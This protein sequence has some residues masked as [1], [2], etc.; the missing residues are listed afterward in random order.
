MGSDTMHKVCFP[1]NG[2]PAIQRALSCYEASGIKQHLVVVGTLAGQ[3]ID[4]VTEKFPNTLFAYQRQANGTANAIRAALNAFPEMDPDANL[5]IAAG[6]RLIDPAVLE[7]FYELYFE[8]NCD[9]ALLSLPGNKKSSGGRVILDSYD[10]VIAIVERA[11]IRQRETFRQLRN[12]KTDFSG[13]AII[14]LMSDIFFAGGEVKPNK[15][16][17]AFGDLFLE[18]KKGKSFSTAELQQRIPE[19][20]TRFDFI[21]SRGMPFSLTPEQALDSG[22]LKT[23]V[24]LLKRKTLDAALASLGAD[25]AQQ[26][27]YLTDIIANTRALANGATVRIERLL[28]DNPEA[29]LGFNDPAELLEVEDTIR[30]QQDSTF[31]AASL[32]EDLFAPLDAWRSALN[33]GLNGSLRNELVDT[34]GD[35]N[36]VVERQLANFKI[37]LEYTGKHIAATEKVGIVRSPG[38]INVMGRHVDHQGGNCNLMTIGYETVMI[39]HPRNDDTVCLHHVNDKLFAPMEFRISDLLKELPWDD[40]TSLVNSQKMQE[41]ISYG[42]SWGQYIQAAVLRFQ[43]QFSSRRLRGMDLF[44]Y[45]NVPMAAGLSSSSS[46][47][48]GTAEAVVEVNELKTRPAKL[49]TLCGEGEWFVGT[50][51]GSADHAAVKMGEKGRVVKVRFFD[52]GVEEV[53][54]FP[55]K[56]IMAICDSGIEARKSSGAKDQFNHRVSCYRIGFMLLKKMFPQYANALHHLRDVNTTT[57]GVPLS[58]IYKMLLRLPEQA[59][60]AE[61]EALLPEIDLTVFWNSHKEPQDGQYPI[62]GVVLY[63]LAECARSA[64]YADCLKKGDM[65]EIGKLMQRSHDGDRVSQNGKPYSAPVDNATLLNLIED[66][67]SGE[68]EKVISAQLCYQPGAYGC[69]LPDIDRMVDL[70]LEC[71][72]VVGA[73][74]A[75]A[76]LGG[77]MMVMV[78]KSHMQELSEYLNKNYYASANRKSNILF[79]T[80]IAGTRMLKFTK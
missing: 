44:V 2:I 27:E 14:Q 57:L 68:P 6:D 40:W 66:L 62:R 67:E 22:C 36:A 32:S 65:K 10:Q 72:G 61:L 23:S 56:Y 16:E 19:A 46:L 38:R 7:N 34:Y 45:G 17:L 18:A 79:C 20:K 80:P 26:E 74:L 9:I 73:Q 3:V 76:G 37:L 35:D 60:R 50:R 58:W 77:C 63:G 78:E 41:L 8:N 52:F 25:N 75:G 33:Q 28:V 59:T 15:L 64:R 1:I 70:S 30:H 69:S 71:P 29:I 51:G 48:V 42:V 53:I 43:K 47:V 21:D 13:D 55:D 39:V 54:D 4:C 12:A 49:I 31:G 24:D 5:L 11:D